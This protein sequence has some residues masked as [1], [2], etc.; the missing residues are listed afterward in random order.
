MDTRKKR[1][2]GKR[3]KKRAAVKRDRSLSARLERILK[4]KKN[5]NHTKAAGL[6]KIA[7]IS[8]AV[9]ALAAVGFHLS[10]NMNKKDVYAASAETAGVQ[11]QNVSAVPTGLAGVIYGVTR[12]EESGGPVY[13]IGTSCEEVL[14]GQRMLSLQDDAGNFNL[15]DSMEAAV[16]TLSYETVSKAARA[17]MMSD[18]DYQTLL[19]IVE[20]EAGGEDTKGRILVANVIMNRVKSDEFPNTITEVVWD[21]SGGAPQFSP[22]YDGRIGTVTVSDETRDAVRQAMEGTDY[23]RGALFFVAKDQA[24]KENVAWFDKDLEHLFEYGVH[25]FY[26]FPSGSHAKKK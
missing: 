18:A 2:S 9:C 26:T 19:R 11:T 6:G 21:N 14:V 3:R 5:I 16:D 15:S 4:I 8:V 7:V 10:K 24:A 12:S 13:R 17:T 20:A 25:D 23:S 22:T 1:L